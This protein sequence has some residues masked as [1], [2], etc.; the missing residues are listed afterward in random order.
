MLIE[1]GVWGQD[2]VVEDV[3]SP[4][5]TKTPKSQ[6]MAEQQLEKKETGDY[7]KR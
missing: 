6:Q 4:S 3:S 5:P 2:S 1:S 7:Q